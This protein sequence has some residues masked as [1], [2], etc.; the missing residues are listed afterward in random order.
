MPIGSLIRAGTSLFEGSKN[1][2]LSKKQFS[3]Q[4]NESIQRRV[5]DAKKAGIHPLFALGASVGASPTH[6]SGDS[7]ISAA[8][9][10][11]ASGVESWQAG[12]ANKRAQEKAD[13]LLSAQ[14]HSH[15]AAAGRDAAEAALLDSQRARLEQ[16]AASQ[17]R[18][19]TPETVGKTYTLGGEA[20]T[21]DVPIF[22]GPAEP[23]NPQVPTQSSMGTEAGVPGMRK[24]FVDTDG[25]VVEFYSDSLQAEELRQAQILMYEASKK[26]KRA[27]KAAK[28]RLRKMGVRFRNVG[29]AKRTS[30]PSMDWVSP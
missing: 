22:Y 4:M 26:G 3:Q 10:A 27:L 9:D 6:V 19:G 20:G 25:T 18:D 8:G 24:R 7:G 17:G 5:K 12:K 14:I 1:R 2:D 23:Y 21:N 11:I 29:K 15:N 13:L 28:A 30:Q 16:D